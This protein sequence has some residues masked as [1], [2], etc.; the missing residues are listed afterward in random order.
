MKIEKDG[1]TITYKDDTLKFYWMSSYPTWLPRLM[2]ESKSLD[3]FFF[4]FKEYW[5]ARGVKEYLNQFTFGKIQGFNW[6]EEIL[7]SWIKTNLP[8]GS[9]VV[10]IDLDLSRKPTTFWAEIP[11]EKRVHLT[12]DVVVFKCENEIQASKLVNSI[13]PN[14]GQA[15]AILDSNVVDWNY[16]HSTGEETK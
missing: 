12:K 2:F 4:S 10:V 6:A 13:E 15:V 3:D 8:K 16:S 7:Y 9:F 5:K 1:I 14:M 11:P